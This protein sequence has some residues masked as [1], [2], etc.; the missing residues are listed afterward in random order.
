[1]PTWYRLTK[2]AAIQ[3]DPPAAVQVIVDHELELGRE[4]RLVHC[5]LFRHD[6]AA[7]EQLDRAVNVAGRDERNLEIVGVPDVVPVE[8]DALDEHDRRDVQPPRVDAAAHL[9]AKLVLPERRTQR[10]VQADRHTVR[11]LV[12]RVG[13]ERL[14]RGIIDKHVRPDA[15]HVDAAFLVGRRGAKDADDGHLFGELAKGK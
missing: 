11:K 13:R 8:W 5:K 3:I 7:L 4:V 1:M 9:A 2:L 14:A 10:C 6:A 15:V 12:H